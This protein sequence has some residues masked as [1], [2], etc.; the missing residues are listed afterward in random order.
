MRSLQA[1]LLNLLLWSVATGATAQTWSISATSQGVVPLVAGTTGA[2]GLSGFTWA[3]GDQY[4]AVSDKGAKLFPLSIQVDA[5]TG[6]IVSSNVS[7]AVQLAAG[8]D[9]EGVAYN[10]GNNGVFASDESGPAIREYSVAGGSLLQTIS[11]PPVFG[12]HRSNLSLESLA[13]QAGA[14]LWTANEEALSTDGPVSSFTAGTVVR[15]QKLDAGLS[16]AGQWAYATGAIHGDLGNNGRDV[17]AS[18]VADLVALPTGDLLVMERALGASP[19]GF[20]IR[21]YQVDFSAAT[22]VSALAA[23]AGETYA[24]VGKTL[25]WEGH[26]PA[27]NFEGIALGPPLAGGLHS[28]LL[29]SD[30]GG[31]LSQGL[32]ALTLA[33]PAC[34]PTPRAGCRVPLRSSLALRRAGGTRDKLAWTWRRGSI[35]SVAA[36]GDPTFVGGTPYALC[37]YDS[38]GGVERFAWSARIAAGEAWRAAGSRGYRYREPS[39]IAAGLIRIVLRSGI[40]RGSA[41]VRGKGT[42]LDPPGDSNMPMLAHDTDVV[43]QLVNLDDP[44]ECLTAVYPNARTNEPDRYKARF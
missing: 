11:V 30:D 16:P 33:P 9:L 14:A 35:E 31:G 19:F 7:P 23:L 26:F 29:L 44:G 2:T 25:L 36:F 18:G 15:L 6:T 17:E 21:I 39:G 13:F 32:Y 42:H 5:N 34:E 41:V 10:P 40:G 1:I 28:L 12:N 38:P 3:G 8:S 43:V 37:V 27:N 24:P 4:Y 20:R 22:D